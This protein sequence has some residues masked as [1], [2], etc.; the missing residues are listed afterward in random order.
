M[1]F[2]YSFLAADSALLHLAKQG[3]PG[4][5]EAGSCVMARAVR[6][7]WSETAAGVFNS[8]GLLLTTSR[9]SGMMVHGQ[10]TIVPAVAPC[11]LRCLKSI[12]RRH[13]HSPKV[14][15]TSGLTSRGLSC[16]VRAEGT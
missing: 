14:H 2:I 16:R 4:I 9:T 1:S 8:A 10:N 11:S 3:A 7:P 12:H 5:S 13:N 6:L 15:S